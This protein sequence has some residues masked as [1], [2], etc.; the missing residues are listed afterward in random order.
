MSLQLTNVQSQRVAFKV[1]TTAPKKY[2]VRPSHGFIE[3]ESVVEIQV[4]LQPQKEAPVSYAHCKDKF[5]IQTAVVEDSSVDK[6]TSELFSS[7]KGNAVQQTKLRVVMIPPT[8][9]PSPV[10]E[11][12][13]MSE[14]IARTVTFGGVQGM[15]SFW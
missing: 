15:S 7:S 2:C 10:P 13:E 14:S 9:P 6:V 11:G 12:H 1:K 4:L 5:L 3:P 8:S